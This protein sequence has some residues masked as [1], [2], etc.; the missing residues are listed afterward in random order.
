M[1][2]MISLG[3]KKDEVSIL[4]HTHP[5]YLLDGLNVSHIFRHQSQFPTWPPSCTRHKVIIPSAILITLIPLTIPFTITLTLTLATPSTS[6]VKILTTSTTQQPHYHTHPVSPTTKP[7]HL[8]P[9]LPHTMTSTKWCMMALAI[10]RRVIRG[11]LRR[12][13]GLGDGVRGAVFRT[14]VPGLALRRRG[15]FC[16]FHSFNSSLTGVI[17]FS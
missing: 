9:N 17:P 15:L 8:V 10:I 2:S 13:G 14:L 12:A 3:Q 7:K 11:A 5:F 16:D 6:I 4:P 1:P